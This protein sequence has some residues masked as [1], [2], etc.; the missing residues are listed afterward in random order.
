M[1]KVN[2]KEKQ[3]IDH[4]ILILIVAAN[5]IVLILTVYIF[6]IA[7]IPPIVAILLILFIGII[8][9]ASCH[10]TTQISEKLIRIRI[11][12]LIP[13]ATRR[14]K[15]DD[16]RDIRCIE[17]D[18]RKNAGGWGMHSGSFEG[19]KCIAM[20]MCGRKGVFIETDKKNILLGSQNPEDLLAAINN[21][22]TSA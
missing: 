4:R 1:E 7:G 3:F 20:N 22:R 8:T 6:H 12:F 16:I 11:G 21:A 10:L 17:Y 19:K 14:I 5:I 15:L 9:L 13:I 2:F 18:P